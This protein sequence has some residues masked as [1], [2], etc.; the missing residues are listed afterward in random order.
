[1]AATL[2]QSNVDIDAVHLTDLFTHGLSGISDLLVGL[3]FSCGVLAIIITVIRSYLASG[4]EKTSVALSRILRIVLTVSI[5]AFFSW[6]SVQVAA[7]M[8]WQGI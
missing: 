4:N 5:L 7:L 1:M 6:G 3:A 8:G 2:V